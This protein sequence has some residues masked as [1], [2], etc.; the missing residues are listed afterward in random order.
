MI[1]DKGEHYNG[2]KSILI[3][4]KK[5]QLEGLL[6]FLKAG[7][8]FSNDLLP[9][10]QLSI[11]P[12]IN[13][14]KMLSTQQVLYKYSA[15]IKCNYRSVRCHVLRWDLLAMVL[16]CRNFRRGRRGRKKKVSLFT[17]AA[18]ATEKTETLLFPLWTGRSFCCTSC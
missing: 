5:Y 12:C 10:G 6:V 14:S 4:M 8:T 7:T 11:H 1:K 17:L 9:L 18:E 15:L 2:K 13:F 16:E 3:L